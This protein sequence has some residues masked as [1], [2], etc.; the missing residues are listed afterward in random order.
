MNPNIL[1]TFFAILT[2]SMLQFTILTS[3]LLLQPR[4]QSQPQNLC[5][6]PP[7]LQQTTEASLTAATLWRLSLSLKKEGSSAP[8]TDVTVSLR[9]EEEPGYEPPQGMVR[10]EACVPEGIVELGVQPQRWQLSED[11]DDRKDSLWIWGLFKEPLY[12]FILFSLGVCS[13]SELALADG[14]RL[15]L[16]CTHK[17]DGG[18]TALTTGDVSIRVPT[19]QN[20]D[21]VGL[22]Q[23]TYQ[24]PVPFGS[25]RFL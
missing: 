1:T 13:G 20:A 2:T 25:A 7:Q 5:C 21:L 15:F 11:P 4:L 19:E 6:A 3:A 16:Q 24:E 8:A 17:G 9:F 14:S 23:F 12:P 18:L 10:V 22:S